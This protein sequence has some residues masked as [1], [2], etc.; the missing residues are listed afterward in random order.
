MHL[1]AGRKAALMM[2]LLTGSVL[3][4]ALPTGLTVSAASAASGQSASPTTTPAQTPE[5]TTGD[6]ERSL[7]VAIKPLDPFVILDTDKKYRGFSIDLWNGIA[8]RNKWKTTWQEHTTV[9][10]LLTSV[11]S[12]ESD[13]GI[14]GITITRSRETEVDFSH[15]MFAS[16]LAIVSA[17]RDDSGF[18][19]TLRQVFSDRLLRMLAILGV[20]IVVVGNFVWLVKFRRRPHTRK[21][22]VGV[23]E[24]IWFAGKTIGSAD[25]GAEE[26]TKPFGRLLALVW[27]FA[28][29]ILIQYFT[30]LTTTALTIQQIDGTIKGPQ[31]LPGKR[32]VTVDGT[33]A[34]SWLDEQGIAHS[35]VK[36]ID[37]AYP[38]LTAGRADAIVFDAPVLLRW[39]ATAGGGKARM[40]GP[41]FKSESYGIAVGSGSPLREQINAT[42]LDMQAD[43]TYLALYNRWFH[44]A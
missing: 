26:P 5:P 33:T 30:A 8:Q 43:G 15:S 16:G 17:K 11:K 31:D 32:V 18:G 13:V 28:G 2:A 21:Y 41:I 25:F 27:M 6:K 35:R 7:T 44:A 36:S 24:G 29:I 14:A 9:T 37:L 3:S 39:V 10:E 22:R 19:H 4:V 34:D 12:G 38:E 40:A 1:R 23:V 20:G 42:L